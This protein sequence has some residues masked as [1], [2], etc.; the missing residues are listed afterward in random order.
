[1]SAEP[2]ESM[3]EEDK[4]AAEWAAALAETKAPAGGNEVA[5]EVAAE[6]VAVDDTVW[7]AASCDTD[8]A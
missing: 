3:S 1:M 7:L 6:S 2:N 5:S 4:M 8:T